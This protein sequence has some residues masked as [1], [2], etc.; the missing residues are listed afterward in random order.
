MHTLTTFKHW[1]HLF[2]DE[3]TKVLNISNQM[4]HEKSFWGIV[5]ITATIAIIFTIL[6]LIAPDATKTYYNIPSMYGPYY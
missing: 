1:A 5:I 6:T 2:H 4:L 3:S